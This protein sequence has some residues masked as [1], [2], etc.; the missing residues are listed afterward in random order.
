[1]RVRRTARKAIADYAIALS[2]YEL[3][4]GTAARSPTSRSSRNAEG[5][6]SALA[7]SIRKQDLPTGGN[8]GFIDD[9]V[10]E[11]TEGE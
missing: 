1:M 8:A 11:L 7:T 10:R 4:P 6:G 3:V 2:A 9:I 5:A